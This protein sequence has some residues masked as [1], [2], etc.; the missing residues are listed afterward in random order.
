[1]STTHT[2]NIFP[3]TSFL[4]VEAALKALAYRRIDPEPYFITIVRGGELVIFSAINREQTGPAL[5]LLGVSR[6]M[7]EKR[8]LR[9]LNGP[10][11]NAALA[12]LDRF[13][14]KETHPGRDY[15]AVHTA[16]AE[17]LKKFQA[18]LSRYR[19]ELV[20]EGTTLTV[21]FTGTGVAPGTRGNI[22]GTPGFEAT[23]DA[24]SLKVLRSHFVR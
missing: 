15:A 19:A 12:S 10:E 9:E 21:I 18:D 22:P 14:K 23:L 13:E 20:R 4:A 3:G 16:A 11:I 7:D 5:A 8:T 17:M 24:A 6:G 1:M 2:E